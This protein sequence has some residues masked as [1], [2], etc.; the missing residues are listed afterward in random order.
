MFLHFK[1]IRLFRKIN[2]NKA[3]ILLNQAMSLPL[4]LPIPK[5]KRGIIISLTEVQLAFDNYLKK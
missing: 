5:K 1:N 4:I 3:N 2:K